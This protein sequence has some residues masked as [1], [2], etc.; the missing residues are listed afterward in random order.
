MASS[1]QGN[2][3]GVT[4][5]HRAELA[6]SALP[7]PPC[8]VPRPYRPAHRTQAACPRFCS[9]IHTGLVRPIH[10]RGVP[11]DSASSNP[12]TRYIATCDIQRG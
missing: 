5:C 3:D 10:S 6:S 2:V 1:S 4:R 9:R 7:S 8:P 11:S 12:R